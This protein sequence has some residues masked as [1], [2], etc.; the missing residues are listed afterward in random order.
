MTSYLRTPLIPMCQWHSWLLH[1][2]K[3][4]YGIWLCIVFI[5]LPEPKILIKWKRITVIIRTFHV[6]FRQNQKKLK[7]GEKKFWRKNTFSIVNWKIYGMFHGKDNYFSSLSDIPK[8]DFLTSTFKHFD[9]VSLW[10]EFPTWF[11]HAFECYCVNVPPNEGLQKKTHFMD[12]QV[13][14]VVKPILFLRIG[15][16]GKLYISFRFK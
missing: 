14:L 6:S 7:F 9:T 12:S 11:E 8:C 16:F 13:I 1:A 3:Q 4:L 10:I 5:A 15:V 2:N